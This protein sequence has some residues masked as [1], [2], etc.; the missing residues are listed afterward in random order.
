MK[1]VKKMFRKLTIATTS[2]THFLALSTY[3]QIRAVSEL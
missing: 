1:N 3:G 2:Q